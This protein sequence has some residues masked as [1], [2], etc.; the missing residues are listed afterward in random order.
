MKTVQEGHWAIAE[1]VVEKRTKARGPGCP[2]G[3]MKVTRTPATAYDIGEWVWGLEEDAPE[4]KAR[5]GNVV[6]HRPECSF[7]A[8]LSKQEATQKARGPQFP[9]DTSGGSP[10]SG[11]GRRMKRPKML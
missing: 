11:G 7:S 9:R 6:N 1:A 5:Q 3:M 8:Y 4:G 2:H 10:S